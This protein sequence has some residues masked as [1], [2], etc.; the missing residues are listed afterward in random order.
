MNIRQPIFDGLNQQDNAH[1]PVHAVIPAG[2]AGTRLWPLSREQF[3]KQ[4]ISLTGDDTLL[5]LTAKRLQG[6][7]ASYPLAAESII[8]C[9]EE[10]RFTT[11]E[12]LRKSAI[13]ARIILEPQA[14][15]TAPALTLAAQSLVS[16]GGDSIMVVMPADHAVVDI[17][18]FQQ[19]V[20]TAIRYA[21][22]GK[23]VTLGIVPTRAETGYGYIKVGALLDE[24]G[25]YV[26]DHFVE[27]PALELAEHYLASG[28]FWWNSGVFVLRAS[29]WL[30][31]IETF[32]PAIHAI[33]VASYEAVA[34]DTDFLRIDAKQF[35][36]CPSQSIDYAVMER[37]ADPDS[38][39][40]AAVVPLDAGWSDVGAWD[41]VWDVLPKDAHG[42]VTRGRVM[43]EGATNTFVHAD[44]RLVACVGTDD[45]IVVE[46]PDAILVA[47]HS[48]AQDVKAVVARIKRESGTEAHYHRKVFRPWGYYDSIDTGENFQVKRIVV[49][50][51]GRLSLQ[52]HYHRAEHWI[53]VRG[54]ARVTRGDESFLL[55][56]N[57]STYIPLGQ[58]HRLE[59]PGKTPLAMIEVQSGSYLGED[60]IVRF[61]DTYGRQ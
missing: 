23:I 10:H 58:S 34:S 12:Q 30:R 60:D 33:C 7:S 35:A 19:A 52:M 5:Q 40:D 8:V 53:V 2:G 26:L 1:L 16:G 24:Q 31:A 28:E 32:A 6:I 14:R 29:V 27:K 17:A 22:E 51:G 55:S 45:L 36:E 43:L 20:A 50:P 46:T 61:E 42:N 37:V 18:A 38:G 59:N 39:F 41:A 9:G 44:G 54:T 48:A 13:K 47:K 3:P 57:Q 56:E 21:G 4:L 15:N 25:G 11:A 49:N